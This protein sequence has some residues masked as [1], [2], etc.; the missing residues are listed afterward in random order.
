MDYGL[1]V[2][3]DAWTVDELLWE[4]AF[5]REH[6]QLWLDWLA[7][8]FDPRYY[9]DATKDSGFFMNVD[10]ALELSAPGRKNRDYFL[11]LL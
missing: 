1:D 7:M 4:M 5:V 11:G 2:D 8:P 10:P 6:L 9:S 3:L